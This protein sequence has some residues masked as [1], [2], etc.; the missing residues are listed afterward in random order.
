MAAYSATGVYPRSSQGP[1]LALLSG[2]S[3]VWRAS[4]CLQHPWRKVMWEYGRVSIGRVS[5]DKWRVVREVSVSVDA[6][7]VARHSRQDVSLI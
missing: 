4:N 1:T 2:Q 5:R 7:I 3:V 6:L